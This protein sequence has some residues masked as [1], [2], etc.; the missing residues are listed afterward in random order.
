MDTSLVRDK[1]SESRH[2][3]AEITD[4][5]EPPALVPIVDALESLADAIE[6]IVDRIN[7]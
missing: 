1:I 4:H 3:I 2:H 5:P 6:A 7:D